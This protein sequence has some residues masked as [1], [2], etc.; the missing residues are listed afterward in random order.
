MTNYA[1]QLEVLMEQYEKQR[2]D[3]IDTQKRIR[4]ISVTVTAPKRT[5]SVTV[6][7]G[8]ITDISFPNG[9]YRSMAPAELASVLMKTIASARRKAINEAA[10]ILQPH[11]PEG[12]SV[13]AM[14]GGDYDPADV[15][16]ETPRTPE[17]VMEFMERRIHADQQRPTGKD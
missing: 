2:A 7:H 5:V 16:P 8:E 13:A 12:L 10:A 4:E 9:A 15:L 6:S 1:E 3:L 11:M 17:S 14:M